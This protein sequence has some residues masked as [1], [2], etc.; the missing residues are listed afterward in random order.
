[1]GLIY[2]IRNNK[3]DKVYIGQTIDP[4]R[5]RWNAH[6]SAA[7]YNKEFLEGNREAPHNK[8]GTCSKLYR[9]MNKH[10]ISNFWIEII[11][12]NID[13]DLLDEIERQYIEEFDSVV[14]GYNLKSGGDRSNHSEE[15]KALLK[16]INAKNMQTT[17]TQFRKHD[18]LNDLPIHCIYVKRKRTEGVAINKHP[19]CSRKE[20]SVKRYG[21]IE[22]A[23]K[24]LVEHL[25]E[26][27][28]TG[29]RQDKLV[30]RD[31]TLPRGVNKIKN[32]YFVDKTIKGVSYR[33]SFSGLTDDEN[34]NNAV[35]YLNNL[36]A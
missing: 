27:E 13:S 31:E 30:K 11:E 35:A 12:D 3:N 8:R 5:I 10:I 22:N 20:F 23:K 25:N 15:T 16:V 21:T 28:K 24:A 26:L 6:K 9:A 4:I 1:M 34:R 33:K 32:S 2:I 29:V 14:K 19:L 7:K 18:D 36:I 17:F